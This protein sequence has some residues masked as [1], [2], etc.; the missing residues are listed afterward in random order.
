VTEHLPIGHGEIV[1]GV[2]GQTRIMPR[3]R[4]R[5]G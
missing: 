1:I 2:R 4:V 3:S 5:L